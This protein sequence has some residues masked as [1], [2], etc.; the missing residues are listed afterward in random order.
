MKTLVIP[1]DFSIPSSHAIDYAADMCHHQDIRQIILFTHFHITLFEQLYPT[2]DF[3]QPGEEEILDEKQRI[4]K[5]LEDT[6]SK[7]LQKLNDQVTVKVRLFELPLLRAVLEVIDQEKPDVLLLGSS[8]PGGEESFIGSKMIEIARI[9]PVPVLIVPNETPYE[10]VTN[11]LIACDFRTLN[12]VSLLGRIHQIKHWPHPKLALLNVDPRQKHLKPEHP[13][14]EINGILKE[15]LK[16]YE[17]ELYYSDDSDILHG[18]LSFADEHH[19]QMIIALPGVHSF[20]YNLT[21]QSITE[22]L[23]KDANKPVLILK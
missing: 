10:P 14:L 9:S 1:V 17:Y 20:L 4:L 8:G 23:S 6:K 11:V 3:I 16:E 7:L 12:H 18:V 19:Q 5:Q 21:H 15:I 13:N 2:P 22:G